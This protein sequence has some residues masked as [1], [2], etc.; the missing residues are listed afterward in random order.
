VRSAA[1]GV[2]LALALVAASAAP[3]RAHGLLERAEP[4][5]GATLRSAPAAVRVWFSERVEIAYST[6]RVFD[7]AGRPVETGAPVVDAAGPRVLRVALPPLAPGDYV[8][9]WRVLSVDSHVTEGEFSFRV[10][11]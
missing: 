5:A 9:R 7:R 11:P 10:A 1:R 8:V 3:G 6:V 4:R 2:L